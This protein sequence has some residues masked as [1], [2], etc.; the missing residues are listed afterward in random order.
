MILN[1]DQVRS[2][3]EEIGLRKI[4]KTSSRKGVNFLF[5][6]PY[7]GERNNPSGSLLVAHDGVYGACFSC[8]ARYSLPM[9]IGECMGGSFADGIDFLQE[10]FNVSFRDFKPTEKAMRRYEDAIDEGVAQT[11]RQELPYY[12]LAPFRSGK[13]THKYFFERGFDKQDMVDN[14]IGWDRIKK[15]VTIPLFHADGVLAGFSGRAVLNEKKA[16]GKKNSSYEKHYGNSPKYLLYDN[17]PIGELLY[18]SHDFFSPD[19][20]AILVEGLLDRV[21]MRKLGFMNS[22]ATIVAKM[23]Y[24]ERTQHSKQADILHKLGVRKIYFMQDA[25]KAGQ[26]GKE[27]AIKFLRKDFICRDVEYPE[28]WKDPMGDIDN[29]IPPLNYEQVQYMLKNSW[30]FG[31]SRKGLRRYEG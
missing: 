9:L 19:G 6:C 28:G 8:D 25:D 23:S 17:V 30:A 24:D 18:G 26:T 7:H 15:R 10:R 21:W 5:L 27:D 1:E 4:K 13:E 11:K 3:L 14:M 12:K 2:I 20:T 29:G 16:N 22:L 31:K